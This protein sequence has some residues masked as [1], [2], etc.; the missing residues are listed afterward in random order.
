MLRYF[1]TLYVWIE[2]KYECLH[3]FFYFCEK[4]THQAK[5][6]EFSTDSCIDFGGKHVLFRK[7]LASNLN[8]KVPKHVK[9]CGLKK[10]QC[11]T[12]GKGDSREKKKNKMFMVLVGERKTLDLE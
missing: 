8:M 3:T 4:I 12:F 5:S 11:F 2:F 1:I 7:W 9:E 10:K 6:C